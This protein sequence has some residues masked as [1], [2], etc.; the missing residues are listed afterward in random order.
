MFPSP[1][2]KTDQG[3]ETVSPLT[4]IAE[5]TYK[6]WVSA[7]RPSGEFER[8]WEE[9]EKEVYQEAPECDRFGAPS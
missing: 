1:A 2:E 5:M 9:A 4:L 7:G 3:K 6:K 8:F